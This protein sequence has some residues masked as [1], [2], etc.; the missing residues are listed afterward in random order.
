MHLPDTARWTVHYRDSRYTPSVREEQQ[1]CVSPTICDRPTADGQ[2]ES[3]APHDFKGDTACKLYRDR[4]LAV[5]QTCYASDGVKVSAALAM[6]AVTPCILV[7]VYQRF[8]RT[9]AQ[10]SIRP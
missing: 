6:K 8:G 2:R 5:T 3:L 7:E 1:F 9:T 4:C 10:L